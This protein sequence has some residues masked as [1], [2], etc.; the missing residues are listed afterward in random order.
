ML[1]M[2]KKT[3]QNNKLMLSQSQGSVTAGEAALVLQTRTAAGDGGMTEGGCGWL[4]PW[5]I[6]SC[7]CSCPIPGHCERQELFLTDCL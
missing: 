2:V 4:F 7:P 3:K 1:R 5:D 6:S